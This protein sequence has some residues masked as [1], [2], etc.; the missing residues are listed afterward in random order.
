MI[1]S[2]E[3]AQKTTFFKKRRRAFTDDKTHFM[4]I[5]SN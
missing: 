1:L 4:N 3:H 5:T 2:S